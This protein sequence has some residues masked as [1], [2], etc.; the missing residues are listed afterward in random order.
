M[1]AEERR[2]QLQRLSNS[3]VQLKS[4]FEYNV[5]LLDGR[6]SEHAKRDAQLAECE[7]QL[8]EQQVLHEQL[9]QELAAANEGALPDSKHSRTRLQ[10]AE[11][12]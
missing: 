3:Y 11:G 7:A 5:Q 9:Q 2:E 4:D 12:V 6:D 10:A 8:Q 1:Q